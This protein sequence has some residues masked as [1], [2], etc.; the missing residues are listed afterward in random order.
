MHK[1]GFIING[2]SRSK[3]AVYKALNR[4]KDTICN[5]EYN[6]VQTSWAGHSYLL[7]KEFS[8]EGYTHI[9][10]V[11]GDG[12]LHEVINGVLNS[13]NTPTV[14]L[15]PSGS[16]NDFA[17]TLN[18]PDNLEEVFDYIQQGYSYEID[19]GKVR[20]MSSNG[21]SEERFFINISDLGIGADVVQKVNRSPRWLGTSFIFYKAIVQSF[22]TYKNKHLKCDTD[23]WSWSGKV[24]S[25]VI[26][27]GQYFGDG[28]CI[29]PD[30]SPSNGL[31][32]IVIIG[33]I[34]IYDYIKQVTKIKKGLKVDHP[35]MEYRV[36]TALTI[37]AEND[38]GIEADGEYLGKT[39]CQLS[40]LP[41]K[42]N[43][44]YKRDN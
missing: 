39:P 38:C 4:L 31:F 2:K 42:L 9:I 35:K 13:G 18:G 3:S 33:D 27:N 41:A 40:I 11:G 17:K 19:A 20:F 21:E 1:V 5:L 23:D 24:N 15:L 22:F 16:G 37:E 28:M 44:L 6:F 25:F 26:A 12:T 8:Q 32:Q 10:A 30:A 34:T 14:G 7:A 43:Y 36:A 29:A